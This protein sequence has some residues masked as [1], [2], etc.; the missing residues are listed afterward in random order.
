MIQLAKALNFLF[1]LLIK[2]YQLLISPFLSGSCRFEPTCSSYALGALDQHGP[3]RGGWLA[4]KRIL[5]CN[6]FGDFGYDP[7]PETNRLSGNSCH[8]H[9]HKKV[10]DVK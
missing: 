2:G 6:P 8:A 3:F 4:L 5:R 9:S 10:L 7:I 1:R